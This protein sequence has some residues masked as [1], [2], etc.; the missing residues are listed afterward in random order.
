M[1]DLSFNIV[2]V[3]EH[4]SLHRPKKRIAFDPERA[5]KDQSRRNSEYR[6]ITRGNVKLGSSVWKFSLP[7]ISSCPGATEWCKRFCYAQDGWYRRALLKRIRRE[8]A[9]V[10]AEPA[11]FVADM[12]HD[13]AK[14]RPKFFRIHDSGDFFSVEYIF[15]W[16][17]VVHD[18][19]DIKF[20]TYTRSWRVPELLPALEQLRR[21]PNLQ[22]FASVDP[23]SGPAPA[24]WRV[25]GFDG[26]GL[27]GV[28]CLVQTG[29]QP[30]CQEC[31]FCMAD[32]P[33]SVLWQYHG[34]KANQLTAGVASAAD[35]A[36]G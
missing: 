8:N 26:Q 20:W 19:P 13:L 33:R 18:H 28:V 2:H 14:A 4:G 17:Q 24:G 31:G 3:A 35:A 34:P 11:Q 22:L 36:T 7:V 25:A 27:P 5:P 15:A 21:L 16:M 30:S 10:A 32:T 9:E 12:R 1:A 23:E 29:R 6:L